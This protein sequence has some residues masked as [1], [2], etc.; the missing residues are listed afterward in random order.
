[1]A[2]DDVGRE[3]PGP[4]QT[5]LESG[6]AGDK[7]FGLSRSVRLNTFE[8]PAAGGGSSLLLFLASNRTSVSRIRFT[9]S[10]TIET[11]CVFQFLFILGSQLEEN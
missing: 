2:E 9:F 1:M 10:L 6:S 11:V 4:K 7:L 8:L 5:G 3:Y